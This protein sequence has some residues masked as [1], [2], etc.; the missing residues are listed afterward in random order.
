MA[1]HGKARDK[2]FSDS[3]KAMR[4]ALGR[5]QSWLVDKLNK[6]DPNIGSSHIYC[7]ESNKMGLAKDVKEEIKKSFRNEVKAQ[8]ET[9]GEW[10][11][12]YIAIRYL[13]EMINLNRYDYK[14]Q[15]RYYDLLRKYI[16]THT[17]LHEWEVKALRKEG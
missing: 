17:E 1:R 8:T 14:K 12:E 3:I 6:I 15:K 16:R 5:T 10:K 13:T 11:K 7:Y 9:Y 2:H 4:I